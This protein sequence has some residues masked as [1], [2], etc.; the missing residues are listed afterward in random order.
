MKLRTAD[1]TNSSYEAVKTWN[2]KFFMVPT[3]RVRIDGRILFPLNK[4]RRENVRRL[5]IAIVNFLSGRNPN[6][7]CCIEINEEF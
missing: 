5:S 2:V 7:F 3:P 6:T 1:E 4:N